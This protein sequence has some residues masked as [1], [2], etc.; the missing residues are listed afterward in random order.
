MHTFV[1]LVNEI[2]NVNF[3]SI[4]NISITEKC[5]AIYFVK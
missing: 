1:F 3:F 4:T 2:E 5:V